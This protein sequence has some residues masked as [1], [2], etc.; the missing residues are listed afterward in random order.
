VVSVLLTL[1]VTLVLVAGC[2]RRDRVRADSTAADSATRAR[3][4]S[5]MSAPVAPAPPEDFVV[6]TGGTS[7]LEFWPLAVAPG[8]QLEETRRIVEHLQA[9]VAILRGFGGATL[10]ATGDGSALLVVLAWDDTSAAESATTAIVG[11]LRTETDSAA[12]RK[13]LGTATSRVVVRR[14]AGAP[15]MLSEAAMVQV[16]RY[17]LKAGHSFGALARLADSNLAMRVLQDTAA[18]GGATLAAT[19][20]GAIYMVMQARNA[21][22][23]GPDLR[24]TGPLPFWAPFAKRSE[25]LM[26]VVASIPRR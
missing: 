24:L 11:W 22:A 13:R 26:A 7:V 8:R 18:Q 21:T 25:E 5:V 15:P 23:L 3:R 19:D 4:D 17:A 12:R 6:D 14:T 2:G 10:L 1:L 20:S 9:D 16:T